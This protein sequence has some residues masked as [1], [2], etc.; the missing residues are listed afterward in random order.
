VYIE[1]LVTTEGDVVGPKLMRGL[2][3]DE[4][5]A[6]RSTPSTSG[7]FQPGTK[8][9]APVPLI[10]LFTVTFRIQWLP[11]ARIP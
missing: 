3:T 9:D 2:P 5:N 6:T 7:S 1:A 10:A 4:L 8:D 11:L